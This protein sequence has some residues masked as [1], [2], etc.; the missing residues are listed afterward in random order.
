MQVLFLIKEIKFSRKSTKEPAQEYN[1]SL[2]ALY[3]IKNRSEHSLEGKSRRKYTEIDYSDK[4]FICDFICGFVMSRRKPYTLSDLS[5]YI[6]HNSDADV[7]YHKIREIVKSRFNMTY[8][9][10]NSRSKCNANKTTF[11][12]RCLFSVTFINTLDKNHLIIN[13]YEW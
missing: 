7:P 9:K 1:I 12:A 6:N 8:K 10:I 13:I 5:R 4:L 3:N 2:S 11:A